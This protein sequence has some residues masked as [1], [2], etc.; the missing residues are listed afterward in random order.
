MTKK[1]ST[2]DMLTVTQ[3]A[4]MLGISYAAALKRVEAIPGTLELGI[5]GRKQRKRMLRVPRREIEAYIRECRKEDI[6]K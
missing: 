6:S 4:D 2:S 5:P 3:V 1:K